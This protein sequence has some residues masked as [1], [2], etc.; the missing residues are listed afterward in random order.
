MLTTTFKNDFEMLHEDFA[1]WNTTLEQVSGVEN[2]QWAW[3]HQPIPPAISSKSA[4]QSGNVLGIDPA[5]G[6][7]VLCLLS[8]SWIDPADDDLINTVGK[9]LIEQVDTASKARGV[10]H[11]FK[12]LNYAAQWQD[13][14]GGYGE[15]NMKKLC[16]ASKKYDPL[17]IFQKAVPGGFK[18]TYCH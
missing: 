5:E 10:Y 12:Y 7:L 16:A 1:L 14:I 3:T 4:P 17:R 18:L 13:P 15:A 2:L 11:P 9:R 8:A 6:A